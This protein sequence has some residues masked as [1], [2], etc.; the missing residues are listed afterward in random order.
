MDKLMDFLKNHIGKIFV[1]LFGML[2]FTFLGNMII[3]VSDGRIDS[4]EFHNLSAGANGIE[5]LLL[6]AVMAV[7]NKKN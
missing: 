4:M 3:A 2:S 7:L 5:L 1:G 6:M